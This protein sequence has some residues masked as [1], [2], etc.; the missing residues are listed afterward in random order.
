MVDPNKIICRNLSFIFPKWRRIQT[1]T[2]ASHGVAGTY[3][4]PL[5]KQTVE[6]ED[7]VCVVCLG[8]VRYGIILNARVHA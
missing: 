5:L 2:R 8:L 4:I 1:C 3:G 6:P 7:D